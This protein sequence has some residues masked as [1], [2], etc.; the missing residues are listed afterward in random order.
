[1]K[2]KLIKLL[3]GYTDIEDFLKDKTVENKR[4]ILTLA[5]KRLFNTIDSDDILQV[6]EGVWIFEGR[7]LTKDEVDIIKNSA[8]S[9]TEGLLF[10]IL[11]KELRY[12]ANRKMF[13]ESQNEM[14]LISGKILLYYID[15]IKTRLK[16]IDN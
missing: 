11:D 10:K 2:N 4:K 3:G 1:M 6:K 5:V 9:F 8:K 7:P 12:Q 15:I 16:R 14:D 13:I